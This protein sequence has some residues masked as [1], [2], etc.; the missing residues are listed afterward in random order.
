VL[1]RFSDAGCEAILLARD[2][3]AGLG[4]SYLGTEH[5]LLGLARQ[6]GTAAARTLGWLDLT[7][8]RLRSVTVR[9]TGRGEHATPQVAPLSPPAEQVIQLALQA[10]EHLGQRKVEPEHLLLALAFAPAGAGTQVLTA[11]HVSPE[12]IRDVLTDK[13]YL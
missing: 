11:C 9:L 6:T 8:D 2:E 13:P 4:H 7:P 12:Q 3:A 1:K 10:A 5:I